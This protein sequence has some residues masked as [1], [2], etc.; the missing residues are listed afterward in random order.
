MVITYRGKVDAGK[1]GGDADYGGLA[2]GTWSATA[3][4]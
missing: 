2:M 3:Q 4:K 1:M